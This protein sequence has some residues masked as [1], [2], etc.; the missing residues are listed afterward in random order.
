MESTGDWE[1]IAIPFNSFSND[2]SAYTGEPITKCEDDPSVCLNDKHLNDIVQ[3]SFW[4]EG[5]A[6]EF[7]F[8]VENVRAGNITVIG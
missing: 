4:M 8:E 6:G 3:I 1:D 5:A 7:D 2:W